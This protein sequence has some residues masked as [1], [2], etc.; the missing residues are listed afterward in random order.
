MNRKIFVAPEFQPKFEKL[1]LL[2]AILSFIYRDFFLKKFTYYLMAHL[3]LCN[4]III[5]II[6]IIIFIERLYV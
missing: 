6:I 4:I 5:I 3:P 2:S 1:I